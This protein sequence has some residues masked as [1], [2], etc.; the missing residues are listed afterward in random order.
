MPTIYRH[1][2]YRFFFYSNE[3]NPPEPAHIHVRN[4]QRVATFWLTPFVF[5]ADSWGMSAVELNE[6]QKIAIEKRDEF[7]RAWHEFFG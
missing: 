6:L 1:H 4:G 7:E 5:L 3:G 2:G